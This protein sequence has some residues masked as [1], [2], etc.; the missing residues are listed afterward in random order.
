[1]SGGA[2]FVAGEIGRVEAEPFDLRVE[3]P[4]G[5]RAWLAVD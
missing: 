4:A 1:M 3:Y 2:S 5:F